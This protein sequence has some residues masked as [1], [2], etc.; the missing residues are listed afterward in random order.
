VRITGAALAPHVRGVDAGQA[1][2]GEQKE[3][4]VAM[5]KLLSFH[6]TSLD[7]YYEGPNQAFDWPIVDEEFNQFALQQLEEADALMFGRV[8]YQMMVG[9]GRRPLPSR[10]TRRSR[11]R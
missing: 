10:T 3:C 5:R 7:G 9:T 6:V 11:R 8:T 1:A 4:E 2:V